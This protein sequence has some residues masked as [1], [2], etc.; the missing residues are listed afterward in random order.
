MGGIIE[1]EALHKSSVSS[2]LPLHSI[3]CS[4]TYR[5]RGNREPGTWDSVGTHGGGINRYRPRLGR[6]I[7]LLPRV[8][9]QRLELLH[10]LLLRSRHLW[11]LLFS[12]L[13][14]PPVPSISP[15]PSFFRCFLLLFLLSL[16]PP[17][18]FGR[19]VDDFAGAA[20]SVRGRRDCAACGVV[21]EG[22]AGG[23]WEISRRGGCE[24]DGVRLDGSCGC[25]AVKEDWRR[26]GGGEVGGRTCW[27]RRPSLWHGG[28]RHS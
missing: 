2:T 16:S 11:N 10:I 6:R 5:L 4:S 1:G 12:F 22:W 20:V 14:L 27:M 28:K 15:S 8:Q 18:S 7:R 3:P 24:G 23:E 26:I 21:F 17:G 13:S 25:G 9:L 19:V